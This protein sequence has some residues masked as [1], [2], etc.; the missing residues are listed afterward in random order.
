M[1]NLSRVAGQNPLWREPGAIEQDCHVRA[2]EASP[3][4]CEPQKKQRVLLRHGRSLHASRLAPGRQDDPAQV[5]DP[6]AVADGL[7][8]KAPLLFQSSRFSRSP[9]GPG[10]QD[11]HCKTTCS[12]ADSRSASAGKT[13]WRWT[14]R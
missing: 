7:A 1:L 12:R 6:E 9:P 8:A 13:A 3:T 14:S 2:F 4:K 5:V 10:S 11:P